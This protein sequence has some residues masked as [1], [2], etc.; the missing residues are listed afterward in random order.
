[1]SLNESKYQC[2]S[3][4]KSFPRH[5][6][7]YCEGDAKKMPNEMHRE[8]EVEQLRTQKRQMQEELEGKV[9]DERRK[10]RRSEAEVDR[11]T[12]Q[13]R[14][15][16]SKRDVHEKENARAAETE[17]LLEEEKAKRTRVESELAV[18]RNNMHRY[19]QERDTVRKE[20]SV[21]AVNHRLEKDLLNDK[22]QK[23]EEVAKKW[24]E[25]AKNAKASEKKAIKAL[26]L[27]RA[28]DEVIDVDELP[29]KDGMRVR[30]KKKDTKKVNTDGNARTT[31]VAE[32]EACVHVCVSCHMGA[33]KWVL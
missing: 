11:L 19:K 10:R 6:R 33:R 16:R 14:D 1:M 8:D 30:G 2:S 20:K 23:L 3:C 15:E 17:R 28:K 18:T 7:R 12:N 31:L 5:E 32:N 27:Y 9:D 26:A 21:A 25:Q 29:M 13:L 24:E 4:N 22:N